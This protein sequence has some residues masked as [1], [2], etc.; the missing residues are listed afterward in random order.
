VGPLENQAVMKR[1]LI[2]AFL[3][4]INFEVISVFGFIKK[5][6]GGIVRPA[7]LQKTL[8]PLDYNLIR[9]Y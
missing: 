8:N 1:N 3:F 4:R 9:V 6:I 5:N 7:P 2:A